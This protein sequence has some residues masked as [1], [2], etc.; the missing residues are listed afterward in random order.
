MPRGLKRI[1]NPFS[2]LTAAIVSVGF[3]SEGGCG[4]SEAADDDDAADDADDW[5]F[6]GG[7][8]GGGGGHCSCRATT[9]LR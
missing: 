8:G 9:G 5:L 7:G 1:S 4:G 6:R 2:V 3:W